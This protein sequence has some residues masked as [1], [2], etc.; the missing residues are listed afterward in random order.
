MHEE[1][2]SLPGLADIESRSGGRLR[3]SGDAYG[4]TLEILRTG[5]CFIPATWP[6]CGQSDTNSTDGAIWRKMVLLDPSIDFGSSEEYSRSY[7]VY[8]PDGDTYSVTNSYPVDGRC[9]WRNWMKGVD[10]S[11]SGAGEPSV[12]SG[13]DDLPYVDTQCDAEGDSALPAALYPELFC[14]A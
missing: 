13:A 1:E 12:T 4:G 9:L 5:E 10:G 6:G 8:D 14:N 11:V 2:S 3:F 7:L